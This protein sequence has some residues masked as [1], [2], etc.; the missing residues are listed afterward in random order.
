MPGRVA[1]TPE[2]LFCC[3]LL[4]QKSERTC[5]KSVRTRITSS[6]WAIT[7]LKARKV[8]ANITCK[9]ESYMLCEDSQITGQYTYRRTEG[10]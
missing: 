10:I 1:A 5:P 4:S 9:R 7:F 8:S 3:L 2:E 6:L